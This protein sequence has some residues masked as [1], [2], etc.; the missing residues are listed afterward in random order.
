[1]TDMQPG[2]A[3]PSPPVLVLAGRIDAADIPVLCDQARQLL[4]AT[5]RFTLR[6]DVRSLKPDAATLNAL[7]RLALTCRRLGRR[8]E[9]HGASARL[10]ELVLFAGLIE[11]LPCLPF[12]RAAGSG[13]QARRQTE[14][15][16]EPG[17]VQEERDP[18]DPIS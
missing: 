17:G 4:R 14:Q 18:C 2:A 7:A 10:E 3:P 9:L 15:R 8:L 16:E 11:V 5:G 12:D 6:C 13:V 1:M